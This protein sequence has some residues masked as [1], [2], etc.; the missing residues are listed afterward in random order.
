MND[1]KL[2]QKAVVVLNYTVQ[3]LIHSDY[4]INWGTC[5]KK[6]SCAKLALATEV[7]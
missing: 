4:I 2:V 7:K 5:M 1:V 3:Q 6:A